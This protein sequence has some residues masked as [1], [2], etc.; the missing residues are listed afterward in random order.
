[1]GVNIGVK[2]P[3]TG[4]KKTNAKNQ[5]A[6]AVE[7]DETGV[8]KQTEDAKK[9]VKAQASRKFLM[10]GDEAKRAILEQQKEK[11]KAQEIRGKFRNFR[12]QAGRQSTITF[13]D[14]ALDKDGLLDIP[15]MYL[16]SVYHANLGANGE[17]INVICTQDTEGNCPICA[18]DKASLVGVLTVVEHIK[19]ESG[20]EVVINPRRLFLPKAQTLRDLQ[21]AA[22]ALDGLR[23]FQF[24]VRR[25]GKKTP[26][27]GDE[28]ELVNETRIPDGK[29]KEV[30]EKVGS[31]ADPIDYDTELSFFTNDE[32]N[33]L[34]IVDG[35]A[36]GAERNRYGNT[37]AGGQHMPNQPQ[38]SA[39]SQDGGSPALP[40]RFEDDL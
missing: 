16:H 18:Y 5:K 21:E 8:V 38:Q 11:E 25:T 19:Y 20:D 9:E 34:G 22:T 15:M 4:A 10:R 28:F 36:K 12:L 27:V 23:G 24:K 2:K 7:M 3:T 33:S 1:M 37:S 30:L 14:G 26:L 39:P 13:L 35:V 32:L 29:L 17:R 40:S 31:S 6:A